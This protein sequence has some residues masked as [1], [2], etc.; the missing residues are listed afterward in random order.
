MCITLFTGLRRIDATAVSYMYQRGLDVV[1]ASLMCSV[2]AEAFQPGA[3]VHS[4]CQTA[5]KLAPTS[6]LQ[7][8]DERPF[9]SVRDYLEKCL[10]VAAKYD[11]VLAAR[12]ELYEKCMLYHCI[13]PLEVLGLAL[14]MFKISAG[15]VRQA[16]IGGTN[17]GRDSDTIA[18]RAA[19]LAGLHTGSK[20]VPEDWMAL[21]KPAVLGR[22]ARTVR[23][24]SLDHS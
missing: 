11:H 16:A 21:F 3:T 1:A 20:S 18:G 6:K 22:S 14:A 5:V 10:E 9:S 2:V 23:N 7:T 8:F 4:I 15:D 17:I 19:M 12:P 24:L 13:D